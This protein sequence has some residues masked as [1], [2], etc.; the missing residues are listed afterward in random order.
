MVGGENVI[1]LIAIIVNDTNIK[2][3]IAVDCKRLLDKPLFKN[4][5]LKA[6]MLT[7]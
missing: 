3:V 2:K 5:F 7:V 4:N 6:D 1:N